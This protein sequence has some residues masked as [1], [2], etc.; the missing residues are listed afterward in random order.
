M[1]WLIVS[2]DHRPE[3]GGIGTH[4]ATFATAAARR[5]WRIDLMTRH[6]APD[7]E[8]VRVRRVRCE[9]D[10]R[11]FGRRLAMLRRIER[12]R[13]YRYGA[14]SLSVAA[15][16]LE[17]D[18]TP[19]V[20]EFVDCR[21]EGWVALHSDAVRERLRGARFLVR[22]HA[23]M[24]LAERIAG[25]DPQRFGRSIYHRWERETLAAAGGVIVPSS[26]HADRLGCP[27][28]V[29]VIPN[30]VEPHEATPPSASELI[31]VAG[32]AQPLKGTDLWAQ[33]LNTVL[34]RRPSATAMML[35]ADTPT[36][37]DGT[38]MIE[39]CRAMI[40]ADLRP[41]VWFE[42]AVSHAR[43]LEAIDAAALVVVPSLHESFS[44]VAA[45]AI[46][47]GRP[48]VMTDGVGLAELIDKPIVVPRGSAEALA[49]GQLR[50]L[51]SREATYPAARDAR[52]Q[53][54]DA[55]DPDRHLDRC[56]AYAASLPSVEPCGATADGIDRMADFLAGVRAHEAIVEAGV[57]PWSATAVAAE[58]LEVGS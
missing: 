36:G 43:V 11:L 19:D 12:V 49:V 53:L 56:A 58:P 25:A 37:P 16:L 24:Y 5:G 1:H 45:E 44:Y 29:P 48:V 3:Q 9:D 7:I 21:A 28:P 6:D 8:G 55:C 15:A 18:A 52:L 54:L 38:T 41:R 47:R 10:E 31:V 51:A 50:V 40:A 39:H 23:P 20:V 13:P 33:S 57:A 46:A 26:G 30:P 27:W 17:L 32:S 42:E 2:A 14:W 34:R 22:S 4:V 35:G